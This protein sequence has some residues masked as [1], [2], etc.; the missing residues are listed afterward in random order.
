MDQLESV[1]KQ[2]SFDAT[3][4]PLEAKAGKRL[5]GYG[6]RLCAAAF[7]RSPEGVERC[8]GELLARAD[9]TTP[10]GLLVH[11]VREGDHLRAPAPTRRSGLDLGR[12]VRA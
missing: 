10:L 2:A 11:M 8:V 9:T 6:R 4:A 5:H 7:Q 12:Y 3:V 1:T